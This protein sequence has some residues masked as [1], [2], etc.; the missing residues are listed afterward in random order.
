MISKVLPY[1]ALF[2]WASLGVLPWLWLLNR[3]DFNL[4]SILAEVLFF[5]L[6]LFTSAVSA[7]SEIRKTP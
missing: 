6:A 3:I 5:I 1:F 7:P 4:A 2:F